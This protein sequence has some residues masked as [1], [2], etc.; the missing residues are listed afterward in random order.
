[1]LEWLRPAWP[2]PPG[3][4]ALT[5]YR[6]GGGSDTPWSGLNL[7]THVGDCAD[8]VRHNRQLLRDQAAL[9]AEPIWLNQQHGNQVLIAGSSL[10]AGT[11]NNADACFTDQS[12]QVCVVLTADCLP[13]LI[14]AADGQK[15]AAIHAGWRGL[16]TG[17]IG[18]TM[19]LFTD[20][21]NGISAWIGPSISARNYHVDEQLRQ[22]FLS[23]D[24]L[25]QACFDSAPSKHSQPQY[26]MNLAAIA[27]LQLINGGVNNIVPSGICSYTEER[28]YSHRRDGVTAR[29]AT[30]IWKSTPM[31]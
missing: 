20:A 9:P 18:R 11:E 12:D 5:S 10:I 24:P 3:I 26:R 15:I 1:M 29:M 19:T 28:Y 30:M 7:A 23:L 8:T 6:A 2:S 4:H 13:I 27:S 21:D 14:C 31:L 17:I 25:Y 22:Q 16:A